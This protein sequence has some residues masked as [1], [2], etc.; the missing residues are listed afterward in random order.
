VPVAAIAATGAA[1]VA[2]ADAHAVCAR[3][4]LQARVTAVRAALAA[5][6]RAEAPAAS[7][8]V[9][10]SRGSAGPPRTSSIAAEDKQGTAQAP[11]LGE[12]SGFSRFVAQAGTWTNWPKWSKW[13]NWANR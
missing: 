5:T 1:A 9:A 13:S 7:E 6:A 11:G 8:L 10:S 4:E 2:P 12:G 3:V